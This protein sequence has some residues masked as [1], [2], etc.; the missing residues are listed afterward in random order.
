MSE[1][2]GPMAE[3]AASV[4][5]ESVRPIVGMEIHVELATASKMFARAPRARRSPGCVDAPDPLANTML[6]PVVLALPGA[7]PGL[8]RR[9]VELSM[10]VGL[11][12]NCSIAGETKWDRKGYTYPDLPKGYQISQYDLPLC[13][14][15]RWT[16][17]RSAR[18]ARSISGASPRLGWASSVRTWRRT[19]AS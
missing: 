5:I 9:A 10:L 11:A 4:E 17:R 3:R 1:A 13:Y 12:L 6:D 16:C 8:N 19:R 2:P 18:R 14:D 7:L 15:G